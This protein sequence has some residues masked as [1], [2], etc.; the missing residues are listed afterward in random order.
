VDGK[1]SVRGAVRAAAGVGDHG[2]R[3]L[4]DV[5]GW[6]LAAILTEHGAKVEGDG[7]QEQEEKGEDMMTTGQGGPGRVQAG[8]SDRMVVA[9]L[10]ADD[11]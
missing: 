8:A 10:D 1:L 2:V 4:A 6:A 11:E 3:R 7:N 9:A 5:E